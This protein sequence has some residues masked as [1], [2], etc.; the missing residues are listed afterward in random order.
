MG[1]MSAAVG[2]STRAHRGLKFWRTEAWLDSALF[3]LSILIAGAPGEYGDVSAVIPSQHVTGVVRR[4]LLLSNLRP[5]AA[6]DF[7]T[8][9]EET[10]CLCITEHDKLID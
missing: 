9:P 2:E 3:P 5:P 1:G 8:P 6:E 10:R 4:N 7:I